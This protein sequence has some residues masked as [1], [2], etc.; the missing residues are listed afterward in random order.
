MLRGPLAALALLCAAL[1]VGGCGRPGGSSPNAP[2]VLTVTADFGR[3]MLIDGVPGPAAGRTVMDLLLRSTAVKT[4]TGGNWVAYVNGIR[5]DDPPAKVK[6]DGGDRVWWDRRPLKPGSPAV[7]GSFPEPFLHGTGGKRLPV[8]VECADPGAEVCSVV[9][10]KLLA[11]G[12]VIGRSN[13]SSSAAD[14]SLRILV[15]PWKALRGRDAE[16]DAIDAGP[17]RSGVFARFD[18][19]GASLA[20]LDPAGRPVRT[21]G[22]GTG[23]I[24]ATRSTQRQPVWFVTGTDDAGVAAAARA[25]DEGALSQRYALAIDDDLPV[26]APAT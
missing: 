2:V 4:T 20:V 6:V 1:I 12:I 10:D 15:G 19:T 9:A 7:V 8:R 25:L 11:L 24:A 14:E 18:A 22:A 16:S 17:A 13:I 3:Q 23:L 26:A 21:L 5:V